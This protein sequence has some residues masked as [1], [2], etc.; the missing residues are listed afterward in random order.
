MAVLICFCGFKSLDYELL[1]VQNLTPKK[2]EESKMKCMTLQ[3]LQIG[4]V[5]EYKKWARVGILMALTSCN[6]HNQLHR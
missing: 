6:S 3:K 2:P 4:Y 5:E 1:R